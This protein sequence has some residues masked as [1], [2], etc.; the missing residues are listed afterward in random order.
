MQPRSPIELLFFSLYGP[1]A[2]YDVPCLE[3]DGI[4]EACQRQTALHALWCYI[5]VCLESLE[6][7]HS[8][9]FEYHYVLSDQ[10]VFVL[11]GYRALSYLAAS[12]L[13]HHFL[14]LAFLSHFEDLGNV[15]LP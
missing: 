1:I 7:S 9:V 6:L 13:S 15:G 3:L 12:N 8:E 5:N 14:A 4:L 11:A 2:L 10:S